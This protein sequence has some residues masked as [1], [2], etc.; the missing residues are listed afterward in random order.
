LLGFKYKLAIR[1]FF[2]QFNRK[3]LAVQP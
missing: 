3:S 1:L 2:S